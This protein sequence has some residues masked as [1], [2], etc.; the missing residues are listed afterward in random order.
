M[1]KNTKAVTIYAIINSLNAKRYIGATT[2]PL[3][4]RWSL[5]KSV[6]KWCGTRSFTPK[7]QS[8][9]TS[10]I[11]SCGVAAFSVKFL[12][13]FQFKSPNEVLDRI[14]KHINGTNDICISSGNCGATVFRNKKH[15]TLSKRAVLTRQQVKFIRK[16]DKSGRE[17]AKKYG[18]SSVTIHNVRKGKTY[19]NV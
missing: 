4:K 16:T 9:L 8:E 1:P 3:G 15:T 17:L 19:V 13:R 14:A 18:V 7:S 5:H 12:E 11:L 6:A 2:L 10:A